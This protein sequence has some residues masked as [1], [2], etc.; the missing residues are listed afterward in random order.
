MSRRIE[1]FSSLPVAGLDQIKLRAELRRIGHM[2][3]ATRTAAE[4]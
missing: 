4:T 3:G 1:A 2:E